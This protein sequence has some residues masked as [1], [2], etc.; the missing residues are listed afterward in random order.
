MLQCFYRY[1]LLQ[2][3]SLN[4]ATN[5]DNY[6]FYAMLI[7]CKCMPLYK[8]LDCDAK[9]EPPYFATTHEKTKRIFD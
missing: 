3:E 2:I 1:F 4:V 8:K 7:T 5:F 9:S 6:C